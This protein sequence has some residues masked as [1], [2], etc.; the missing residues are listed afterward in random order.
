MPRAQRAAGPV[1]GDDAG[2]GVPLR[3]GVISGRGGPGR[4][5]RAAG[6]RFGTALRPDGSE[7]ARERRER[8]RGR[9]VLGRGVRCGPQAAAQRGR[10]DPAHPPRWPPAPPGRCRVLCLARLP[11]GP[12]PAAGR[13]RAAAGV[14]LGAGHRAAGAC[15]PAVPRRPAPVAALAP[16]ALVLPRGCVPG[17]EH[18]RARGYRPHRA[19]CP[20]RFRRGPDGR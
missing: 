2:Q 12:P 9:A 17:R 3:C 4:C 20:R 15:D 1:P 13:G 14:F 6:R 8:R 7:R 10:L 18:V 16:G 5:C 11:S 19:P